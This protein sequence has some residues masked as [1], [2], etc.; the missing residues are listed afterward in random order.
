MSV[1]PKDR[2]DAG[3]WQVDWES[4]RRVQLTAAMDA[5]PARRLAW[6][7]EM[8]QLAYRVGALK[9]PRTSRSSPASTNR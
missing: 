2:S 1:L 3:D 4:H 9:P 7:E 5:T 6:L 8:L